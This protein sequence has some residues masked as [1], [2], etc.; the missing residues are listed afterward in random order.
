MKNSKVGVLLIACLMLLS[1]SSCE[2][3][4]IDYINTV[5][6]ETDT[7]GTEST[8]GAET[9]T[10]T[11]EV[12]S[13]SEAESET[14]AESEETA[15]ESE[16]EKETQP[17]GTVSYTDSQQFS[18]A[19]L[20]SIEMLR[21]EMA[22]VPS[23]PAIFG[24][25]YV[26][27]Y[28]DDG[29]RGELDEWLT[30]VMKIMPNRYH[31][32]I[33]EIDKNHIVG[34]EG[35]LYCIIAQDPDSTISV[36]DLETR[37]LL[38]QSKNGDP[39]LVFC[40][41]NGDAQ[42]ADTFVTIKTTDGNEYVWEPTLSERTYPDM[43]FP[44][45]LVDKEYRL[46]SWDFG[47]VFEEPIYDFEGWLKLG[48]RGLTAVGLAYD[49]NG[50]SW[51]IT[52]WNKDARYTLTFNIAENDNHLNGE[53][54]LDCYYLGSDELQAEWRGWWKIETSLE[55]PSLLYLYNMNLVDGA[56][57]AA[58][59][60]I[61]FKSGMYWLL[62]PQSGECITLV[63]EDYDTNGAILPIFPEGEY[64]VTLD[65][66]TE[67]V[68]HEFKDD[69][70]VP[71][72][73]NQQFSE[74]G[75]TSIDVLREE[76]RDVPSDPAE[77]GMCYIGYYEYV[78]ETEID[79]GQWYEHTA[80]YYADRY[81]FVAE[82]DAAHTIGSSGHLYCVVGGEN[83]S[84]IFVSDLVSGEVLYRAENG[85]PILVFCNHDGD[86]HIADTVVTIRTKDGNEYN[87]EPKLDDFNYP[88]ILV[89][90]ERRL[91]SWNIG[92]LIIE[93]GYD[94]DTWYESGWLGLT[95]VGLAYDENGTT[96]IYTYYTRGEESVSYQL[97]FRLAENEAYDGE[98][99]LECYYSDSDKVQ[100]EW[101]GYW[102][103]ETEPEKA[104]TLYVDM[105][106]INSLDRSAF[107]SCSE[108]SESYKLLVSP[109]GDE[110]LLVTDE[111][112]S[113]VL[114][115]FPK[116]WQAVGLQWIDPNAVG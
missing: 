59:E 44:N 72:T 19:A 113:A 6:T 38:Y 78:E 65:L 95:P 90:D 92:N 24:M 74:A 112:C 62:A 8:D 102:R 25:A 12:E 21:E 9:E 20:N 108:I 57:M 32:F 26:G 116:G 34:E 22:T 15:A 87:W 35:F 53:A 104:S 43:V 67:T 85:D 52:D 29:I 3:Q 13:E 48:W 80:A 111:S 31:A 4:V 97:T 89:G 5:I 106:L 68:E 64:N 73:E 17:E 79:F 86:A 115:V 55:M 88:E 49:E 77:F 91:L 39:I 40:N 14:E 10:D 75:G 7:D 105:S 114:P 81:P 103:I 42:E 16:D 28:F 37:E 71:Y 98:V 51:S 2:E 18:E 58:F 46:L 27:P 47:N 63:A 50:T 93:P 96:W 45:I 110:I 76:M 100:A 54:I 60:A 99:V 23:E 61:S 84:S 82:I 41:R 83:T 69:E 36:N 107:E 109:A 70:S 30:S 94:F 1:L 33:P 66:V 101:L 11:D 56:D